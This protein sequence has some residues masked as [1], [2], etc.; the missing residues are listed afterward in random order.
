MSLRV[1]STVRQIEAKLR[2]S[3]VDLY[4]LAGQSYRLLGS[5]ETAAK[6]GAEIVESLEQGLTEIRPRLARVDQSVTNLI[7]QI[8]RGSETLKDALAEP[9]IRFRAAVA[10][11]RTAFGTLR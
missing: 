10:A 1:R 5:L 8:K 11:I 6:K 3:G 9:L 7:E 4:D 2:A